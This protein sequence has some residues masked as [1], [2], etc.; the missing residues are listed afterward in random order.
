MSAT[1]LV[2]EDDPASLDL[3]TYLLAA[4]GYQSLGASRGDEG[5]L[6][7]QRQRP[8]LVICDIQLPGIDGYSIARMLKSD[9]VLSTLPLVAVTA[10]AMVGDRDR[11]LSAGFDGYVSKPID[12]H[13]FVAQIEPFLKPEHRFAPR[14]RTQTHEVAKPAAVRYRGT[15]LVVD[16]APVNRE[17]KR[18]IFEPLGFQVLTAATAAAGLSL[19]HQHRPDLIISD[20]GLPDASGLELLGKVKSAPHLRRIPVVIITATH[21][22]PA[23]R[24][25]ALSLGAARFLVRPLDSS[26]VLREIESCL[27]QAQGDAHG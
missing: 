14:A 12:P 27:A 9:E 4:H 5:L 26:Q 13:T 21:A 17:L 15:I 22:Q 25:E 1:I 3:M 6:M 24:D 20:I 8:D 10:M 23:L 11:V 7:A 2:I 18:S 19:A 16:D